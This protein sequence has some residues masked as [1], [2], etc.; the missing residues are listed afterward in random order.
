[1]LGGHITSLRD[2]N[3]AKIMARNRSTSP[4]HSGFNVIFGTV[5]KYESY[6]TKLLLQSRDMEPF[7]TFLHAVSYLIY[8]FILNL[9]WDG[10]SYCQ[11][12]KK[13]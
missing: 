13:Q 6:D 12:E 2:F 4:K 11:D 1:M 9:T 7:V 8:S 3:K 5:I 10:F